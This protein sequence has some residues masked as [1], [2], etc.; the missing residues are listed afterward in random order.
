MI[1]Q[2]FKE[3]FRPDYL[4]GPE[5]WGA[6][7]FAFMGI[8]GAL[9]NLGTELAWIQHG[10]RD[11]LM[12]Q[13]LTAGFFICCG[14]IY[15]TLFFA[16]PKSKRAGIFANIFAASTLGMI[17][18]YLIQYLAVSFGLSPAL[19]PWKRLVAGFIF[20]ALLFSGYGFSFAN[21]LKMRELIREVS[22]SRAE[23]KNFIENARQI[24]VDEFDE[25]AAQIRATLGPKLDHVQKLIQGRNSSQDTIRLLRYL[26]QAEVRPTSHQLAHKQSKELVAKTRELAEGKVNIG[27]SYNFSKTLFPGAYFVMLVF[28]ISAFNALSHLTS[29]VSVLL[30]CVL[31]TL[32]L[33]AIKYLSRSLSPLKDWQIAVGLVVVGSVQFVF[34]LGISIALRE[35]ELIP[36]LLYYSVAMTAGLFL[37]G[38]YSVLSQYREQLYDELQRT[39]QKLL[40]AVTRIKQ[41]LWLSRRQLIS[42]LHGTVQ[43]ALTAAIT[44]LSTAPENDATAVARA[45]EDL[46]RAVLA[47]RQGSL[48][49]IELSSALGELRTSWEGVC[50]FTWRVSQSDLDLIELHEKN[51][52]YI[53][54]IATESIS[55]AMRHGGAT[56]VEMSMT[57]QDGWRLLLEIA[58]DGTPPPPEITSGTGTKLI[59][60]LSSSWAFS[61]EDGKSVLKLELPLSD[62]FLVAEKETQEIAGGG[63][64]STIEAIF[65]R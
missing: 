41:D 16:K 7:L 58:N 64:A 8:F 48:Q 46:D 55:N 60:E 33:L 47:L 36:L 43:G 1:R 45:Q 20:G 17:H 18:S 28:T 25:Q 26:V 14:L 40:R 37:N 21:Q 31:S 30:L 53:V 49:E 42:Q 15:R 59:S 62:E 61:Q 4:S 2:K 32:L 56:K 35:R 13:G 12:I 65:Q 54:A 52:F 57:T 9:L 19:E 29:P 22:I 24:V 27:A 23:L 6:G 44:R 10:Y 11:W 3:L 39:N 5:I 34:G 38:S 51:A 63:V 50:D